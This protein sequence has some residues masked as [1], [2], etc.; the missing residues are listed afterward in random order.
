MHCQKL[1][2]VAE[3]DVDGVG[4]ET[5]AHDHMLSVLLKL[6]CAVRVEKLVLRGH[7]TAQKRQ[8][9]GP[10]VEMSG[11]G[12]IRA[13]FRVLLKVKR[14]MSKQDLETSRVSRSEM[15][16]YVVIFHACRNKIAVVRLIEIQAA[17]ADF[18][19]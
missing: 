18:L 5:A 15:T 13:P 2:A 6:A 12:K 9:D 19:I 11:Q 10:A 4:S 14:R 1:W 16:L 8:A 17:D 7:D 3:T